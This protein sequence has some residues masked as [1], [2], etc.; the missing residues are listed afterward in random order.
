[1]NERARFQRDA[2]TARA[3][4]L[5]SDRLERRVDLGHQVVEGLRVAFTN[6]PEHPSNCEGH[7]SSYAEG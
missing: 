6:R 5:A 4:A 3:E 2:S 1:V 7:R